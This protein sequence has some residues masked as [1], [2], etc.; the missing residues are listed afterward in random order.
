MAPNGTETKTK[1]AEEKTPDDFL[2]SRGI[3]L[4][5]EHIEM[6]IEWRAEISH[7]KA[8]DEVK[9]LL[10]KPGDGAFVVKITS[11]IAAIVVSIVVI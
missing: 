8:D 2:V 10:W 9:S 7:G 5:H 1:I 4:L 6:Y 3:K 11:S